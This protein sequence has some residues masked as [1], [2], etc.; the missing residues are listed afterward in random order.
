M[1]TVFSYQQ[2]G[3]IGIMNYLILEVMVVIGRVRLISNLQTM[4]GITISTQLIV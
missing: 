3:I 4:H 2:Q 1:E